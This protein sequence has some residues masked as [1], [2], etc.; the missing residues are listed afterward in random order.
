[1]NTVCVTGALITDPASRDLPGKQVVR[2]RLAVDDDNH[3]PTH[4]EVECWGHVARAVGRYLTKSRRVAVTG[5][6]NRAAWSGS[7]A[8]ECRHERVFVTARTVDFLDKPA[9]DPMA[10]T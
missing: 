10:R 8:G 5:R 7:G 9:N 3:K 6:L 1:M 4:V 2:F